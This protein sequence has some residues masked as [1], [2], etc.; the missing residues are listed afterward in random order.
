MLI[1]TRLGKKT[2][3]MNTILSFSPLKK[4]NVRISQPE[5]LVLRTTP[6]GM[7]D[8]GARGWLICP[9]EGV[10]RMRDTYMSYICPAMIG[11]IQPRSVLQVVPPLPTYQRRAV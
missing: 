9:A 10:A 6:N 5:L 2:R 7:C 11:N 1:E 3:D 4:D 8:I